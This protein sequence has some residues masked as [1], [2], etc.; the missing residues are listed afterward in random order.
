MTVN[1]V[2]P[3]SRKD[4][5]LPVRGS[6]LVSVYSGNTDM[7]MD[8]TNAEKIQPQNTSGCVQFKDIIIIIKGGG[9]SC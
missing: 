8:S 5:M 9:N 6:E 4:S 3:A 7:K 1:A 2:M